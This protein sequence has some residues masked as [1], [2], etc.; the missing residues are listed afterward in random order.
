VHDPIHHKAAR[1][2]FQFLGDILAKPF[3]LG[4]PQFAETVRKGIP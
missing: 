3:E 4:H 2:I 1:N